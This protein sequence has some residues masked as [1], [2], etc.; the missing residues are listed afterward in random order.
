MKIKD[1]FDF[2]NS[3]FP[4][5]TACDFDNPGILTGDPETEV[6][7]A[8]IALDC[9]PDVIRTALENGCNLIITHHPVIFEPL[10]SVLAGS[11]VFELVKSGIAVISMHT[12]LDIGADGVNDTL[13]KVL[14]LSNIQKVAA[15]DGFM[16][17]KGTLSTGTTADRLAEHINSALNT[18]VKYNLPDRTVKNVLVCSGSGGNYVYEVKKHKCDALITADVKHNIFIDAQWLGVTV[19]DAGHFETE[20]VIIGPLKNMLEKQFNTVKFIAD[21]TSPIYYK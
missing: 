15:S 11:P 2:L 20:N 10:K 9:T 7:G 6:S 17:N 21:L 16:I 8:V 4:V 3:K 19:F 18:R 14:K 13:C 5:E 1:I 12:N